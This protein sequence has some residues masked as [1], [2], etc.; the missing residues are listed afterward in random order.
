MNL[1]ELNVSSNIDR[2]I[3]RLFQVEDPVMLSDKLLGYGVE[4]VQSVVVQVAVTGRKDIAFA[5]FNRQLEEH[6]TQ[7][8][9][10][11]G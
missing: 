9:F 2:F 6:F 8:F 11:S 3:S 4:L 5:H 10:K 1:F 7:V